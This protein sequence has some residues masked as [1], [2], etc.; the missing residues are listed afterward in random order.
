MNMDII[1]QKWYNIQSNLKI[2][3]GT[4]KQEVPEQKM[5]IRYFTGMEKVLEL[6]GNIGRNS[7]IIASILKDQKNLVTLESC[8]KIESNLKENRNLNNFTFNIENAALSNRDLI[9]KRWDTI[10]YKAKKWKTKKKRGWK[11]INTITLEKLKEKYKIKF[12]TLVIDCEGAFYNI[13]KDMPEIL[14][15]IN[16]I[17]MENDYKNMQHKK[18]V[19]KVLLEDNFYRDYVECEPKKQCWRGGEHPCWKIFFEVWKR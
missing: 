13:L 11:K 17:I 10:P 18:Y 3:H 9:Q 2:K 15:N 19:D 4:F 6:G 16:L 8:P 12:D 5:V 14:T 7:L 1:D